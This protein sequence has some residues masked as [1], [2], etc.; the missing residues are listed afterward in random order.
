MQSQLTPHNPNHPCNPL[1]LSGLGSSLVGVDLLAVLVVADSWRRG[2]VAATLA[3]SDTTERIVS[4]SV[5][6][7]ERMFNQGSSE[8]RNVPNDLA[9]DG[10]RDTVL[11]LQVHLGNGVFMEYR[12]VRD[13]PCE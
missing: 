12:C 10:A 13:I 4:P 9:V 6:K 2:T 5:L 8:V 3:G 1:C 7:Q 11:Q